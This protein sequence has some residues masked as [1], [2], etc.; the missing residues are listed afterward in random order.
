MTF[1]EFIKNP[2][3]EKLA[4]QQ[5]WTIS[6]TDKMPLDVKLFL[7]SKG[8]K[9]QGAAFQ[10]KHSLA[11]LYTV[12]E[13]FPHSKNFAFF[14]NIQENPYIILDIEKTCPEEVRQELVKIPSLYM[15]RS[16]SGKGIHSIIPIP[17]KYKDH[18]ELIK[19]KILAD[20]KG[21][22]EILLNHFVT[23]TGD[24]VEQESKDGSI[25]PWIKKLIEAPLAEKRDVQITIEKPSIPQ[26]SSLSNALSQIEYNKSPSDFLKEDG[27]PDNSKYEYG[28]ISYHMHRL[29]RILELSYYNSIDYTDNQLAWLLYEAVKKKLEPRPKHKEF[30]SGMPWLLWIA[31]DCVAKAKRVKRD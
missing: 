30:R 11:D 1:E 14:F 27:S 17:K 2:V 12:H 8:Q 10:N 25:E 16:M 31:S 23:F 29:F 9:I 22:Y 18:P 4:S 15:E 13:T 20:K 6:S 21:S 5:R 19:R 28:M 26:E 24:I 3:I 7:S